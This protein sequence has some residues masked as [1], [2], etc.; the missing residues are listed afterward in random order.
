MARPSIRLLPDRT[1]AKEE[2]IARY[3]TPFTQSAETSPVDG[4]DSAV[5]VAVGG[6]LCLA[7]LASGEIIGWGA[8]EEGQVSDGTR[9]DR[10]TPV[11]AT[12]LA[13]P[14]TLIAAGTAER[15]NRTWRSACG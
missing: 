12:G 3:I 2:V 8:N 10:G 5:A 15:V 6:F 13:R 9:I 11:N 14:V 1:A 7:L 4:T